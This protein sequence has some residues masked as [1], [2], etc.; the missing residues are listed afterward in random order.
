M[1]K[2]VNKKNEVIETTE[3]TNTYQIQTP[4]AFKKDLL[5]KLHETNH[6]DNIT[7]DCMLLEQAG[8]PVKVIEGDYTNIKITT[9]ED[10]DILELLMK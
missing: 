5:L 3:R 7:D 2:I 9:K 8:Y 6:Q 4:Q 10:L 1:R